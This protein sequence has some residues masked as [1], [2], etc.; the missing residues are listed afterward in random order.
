MRRFG[1]IK[2]IKRRGKTI[3]YYYVSVYDP[4]K[5]QTR[6]V[7]TNCERLADAKD[8]VEARRKEEILGLVAEDSRGD[9]GFDDAVG[10]WLN[11]RAGTVSA[12]TLRNMESRSAR[13]IAHFGSRTLSSI[14]TAAVREYLRH[15]S[16]DTVGKKDPKPISATTVNNDL[17]NLKAFFSF[18][19]DE[20][21]LISSPCSR[22]KPYSAEIKRRVRSLSHDEEARL[23]EACRDTYRRSATGARNQTKDDAHWKQTYTP[24]KYLHT[25]VLIALRC[26]FRR[27]TL[28]S[29]TWDHV[30][31]DGGRWSIPGE[32]MKT[33][34]D[35]RQ[36][37]PDS[38]L[39]ELRAWRLRKP[40]GS[41]LGL[42]EGSTVRK[43]FASA[44]KRAGLAGLTLHDCR[45]IYLNRLRALGV[46]IETAMSLTGHKS[47]ET[48]MKHYREIPDSEVREAVRR[49]DLLEPRQ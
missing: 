4:A 38:V 35:Y 34:E 18:C 41:I 40:F 23:L 28:F 27:R 49:I 1:G 37:I 31:F 9:I 44:A 43:S 39:K 10:D 14:D 21:L 45:R 32:L 24:P 42:D 20:G 7:S 30:D 12:V 2:K 16:L 13:F 6:W 19:V 5:R 29:L 26:G 17:R 25:L 48:V 46:S 33:R 36:P 15:R 8:W 11:S 22:L 47:L 3:R